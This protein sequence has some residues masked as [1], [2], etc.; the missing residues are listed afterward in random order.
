MKAEDYVDTAFCE[1]NNTFDTNLNGV[2]HDDEPLNKMGIAIC[3][4][5]T[6]QC[7]EDASNW[8]ILKL[9]KV[10]MFLKK[11]KGKRIAR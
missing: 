7:Y 9:S 10:Q 1:F 5:S 8:K 11:N 6:V 4:P 3:N 2:Y